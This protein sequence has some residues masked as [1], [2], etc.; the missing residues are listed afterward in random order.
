M[1]DEAAPLQFD[2]D[3]AAFGFLYRCTQRAK[4]RLDVS[5][6]DARRCR[7]GEHA[8]ERALL[9]LVHAS[10]DIKFGAI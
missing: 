6:R 4:Q 1:N 9:L 3:S 8:G 10:Y 7:R 2:Q 5:P